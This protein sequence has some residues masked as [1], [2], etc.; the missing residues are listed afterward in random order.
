MTERVH[1]ESAR[2]KLEMEQME[3][4]HAEL[5]VSGHTHVFA[6]DVATLLCKCPWTRLHHVIAN[7]LIYPVCL[8][9]K[10]QESG[11]YD[12]ATNNAAK[13]EAENTLSA[14]SQAIWE[15]KS[16]LKEIEHTQRKQV[17]GMPSHF[18]PAPQPMHNFVEEEE[19][20]EAPPPPPR[21]TAG[22]PRKLSEKQKR[23]AAL[24]QRNE[25]VE[26][27]TVSNSSLIHNSRSV[28]SR[29]KAAPGS[30]SNPRP[31]RRRE[32]SVPDADTADDAASGEA[33]AAQ[34]QP[35]A[36]TNEQ[37]N[38]RSVLRRLKTGGGTPTRKRPTKGET[39][40]RPP[41]TRDGSV[42]DAASKP[43]PSSR[44]V[45]GRISQSNARANEP[46]KDTAA[47]VSSQEDVAIEIDLEGAK[48]R[49]ARTM[50]MM[51]SAMAHGADVTA[52]ANASTPP[53][54]G[55]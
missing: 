23:A 8:L 39:P 6:A 48:S 9:Q 41:P 2:I 5:S 30:S 24:Q 51:M 19:E 3:R 13:E 1:A 35:P 47:A 14:L 32:I 42:D 16:K 31:T 38:S 49:S 12:H 29:L 7:D 33:P 21:N 36:T 46:I 43:K 17:V 27:K 40:A 45:I 34:E 55:D 37:G 18:A 26:S 10:D 28:V 54:V 53:R 52:I 25:T 22:T 50:S 44:S 11:V 15:S 20:E 4:I